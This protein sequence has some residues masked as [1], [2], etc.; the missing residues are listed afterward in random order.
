M[1]AIDYTIPTRP[2]R[3]HLASLRL[4]S[5]GGKPDSPV[6]MSL[7]PPWMVPIILDFP[8]FTL[9][10]LDDLHRRNFAQAEFKQF[11]RIDPQETAHRMFQAVQGV[12]PRDQERVRN[13]FNNVLLGLGIGGALVWW[14]ALAGA[15]IL[16][17]LGPVGAVIGLIALILGFIILAIV[18][19]LMVIITIVKAI[20]GVNAVAVEQYVLGTA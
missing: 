1:T 8:Q 16:L 13:I 18:A 2:I 9:E 12:D 17:K 11:E 14:V 10:M 20:I 7:I 3:D 6:D 15:I 4:A 19:A 5:P